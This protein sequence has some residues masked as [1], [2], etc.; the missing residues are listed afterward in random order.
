M[1]RKL[2]FLKRFTT[3]SQKSEDKYV[4]FSVKNI[5]KLNFE[6]VSLLFPQKNSETFSNSLKYALFTPKNRC[7]RGKMRQKVVKNFKNSQNVHFSKSPPTQKT[8][9]TRAG[10]LFYLLLFASVQSNKFFQICVSVF[11]LLFV[12]CEQ[13]C[14]F[15][16]I[17][18]F[19]KIVT[20]PLHPGM[21]GNHL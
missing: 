1:I 5:Y 8:P 13:S 10:V 6:K 14:S 2:T 19:Q 4:H 15:F 11:C 9:A 21:P 7:F 12:Q 17:G 16:R 3:F 20:K 18:T